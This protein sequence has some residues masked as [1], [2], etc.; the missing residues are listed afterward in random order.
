VSDGRVAA[1]TQ[2]APAELPGVQD[3]SRVAAG[4]YKVDPDHTQVLFTVNHLSFSLYTGQFIQPAG[5]LAI[6]PAR[7]NDAK[8]EVSFP[9]APVST[10]SDHLNQILQASDFFDA[11][12]F[13]EARFTSTKVVAN[14]VEATIQGELTIKG[15]TRPGT[16]Q[17]HFVGAGVNPRPNKATIGFAATAVIKRSDF[18]IDIGILSVE[19]NGSIERSTGRA[20]VLAIIV[21]AIFVVGE[22]WRPDDPVE[23]QLV[24]RRVG[25]KLPHSLRPN[26]REIRPQPMGKQPQRQTSP[27]HSVGKA[28]GRTRP[29]GMA[30][31]SPTAPRP[32]TARSRSL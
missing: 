1:S 4:V 23:D 12:S 26:Q 9:I 6:D 32:R 10:T 5:N 20:I 22:I 21:I 30:L 2:Q 17:A 15:A 8:V 25:P 7:A 27:A 13:P 29:R 11:G 28:L 18:G 24:R 16:L 3:A 31:C 19:G 14:G